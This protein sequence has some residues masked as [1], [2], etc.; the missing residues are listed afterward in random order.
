MDKGTSTPPL[1]RKLA[2]EWVGSA[3]GMAWVLPENGQGMV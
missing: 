1:G 3:T 2:G